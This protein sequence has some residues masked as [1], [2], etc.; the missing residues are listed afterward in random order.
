ML[1]CSGQM[2]TCATTKMN[3]CTGKNIFSV[4]TSYHFIYLFLYGALDDLGSLLGLYGGSC[5]STNPAVSCTLAWSWTTA[6]PNSSLL[7]AA[8]SSSSCWSQMRWRRG[9]ARALATL[10]FSCFIFLFIIWM[11]SYT[12]VIVLSWF[13]CNSLIRMAMCTWR[14]WWRTLC[15]GCRHPLGSNQTVAYRAMVSS[16]HLA[17]ITSSFWVLSLPTRAALSCWRN[18]VSSSGELKAI[19]EVR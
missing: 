15:S 3:K 9:S 2:S 6:K 7:L 12:F 19:A 5:S 17:S 4:I 18:A 10:L 8:S 13:V 16:T 1:C 14:T 11:P